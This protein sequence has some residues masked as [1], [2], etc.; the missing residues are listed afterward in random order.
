MLAL[1]GVVKRYGATV[2]LDGVSVRL[3]PGERVVLT[4]PN[5]A[6]K[7]TLL[8]VAA[9][10][11]QADAGLI[12]V[13]GHD[14][15][16]PRAQAAAGVGYVG[17]AALLNGELTVEEALS[18]TAGL[19]GV[20]RAKVAG[21][22]EA[23]LQ[24]SGLRGLRSIRVTRLSEGQRKRVSIA[25][26]LVHDPPVLLLDE[27]FTS[28][29]SEG[30][31]WLAERLA[32]D[33]GRTV[34]LA[35]H[36]LEFPGR[37]GFRTIELRAGRVVE[38]PSGAGA[39]GSE[40]AADDHAPLAG[41]PKSS[42]ATALRLLLEKDLRVEWRN[43]M[44]LRALAL[45]AAAMA[46]V[47]GFAFRGVEAVPAALSG[48]IWLLALFTQILFIGQAYRSEVADRA[49]DA[50]LASPSPRRCIALSKT[51][52]GAAA[53]AVA[54]GVSLVLLAWFEG[55]LLP[56]SP[57]VL[58]LLLLETVG[59]VAL[60]TLFCAPAAADGEPTPDLYAMALLGVAPCVFIGAESTRRLFE[61][62]D[63]WAAAPAVGL[64]AVYAAGLCVVAAV[65]VGA[66]AMD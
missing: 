39:E 27:P 66:F 44:R 65:G 35:T 32:C 25:R 20:T 43:P 38:A 40:R 64:V 3:A 57:V 47:G 55:T 24:E 21:V 34:L 53:A 33:V 30:R 1:E 6:G 18:F 59:L 51:A 48:L 5:G 11:V 63:V 2:V 15:R 19:H 50:L 52:V 45:F 61:T 8:R 56:L 9:G 14:R 13:A 60:G 36:D 42:A 12:R 4:G 26:A 62:G 28:L 49:I 37:G 17:H 29:D 23:L 41:K 31:A 22:V 46:L 54:Q 7:S 16:S 10:L 58:V